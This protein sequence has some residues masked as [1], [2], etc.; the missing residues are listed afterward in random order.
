MS[1]ARPDRPTFD[2]HGLRV[3][4]PLMGKSKSAAKDAAEDGQTASDEQSIGSP[5]S[6]RLDR[7]LEA[8]EQFGE[9]INLLLQ[10]VMFIVRLD[11]QIG[12]DSQ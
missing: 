5:T 10:L 4:L 7:L 3:I 1:A 6:S 2:A 8:V 9:R 12:A 11:Q